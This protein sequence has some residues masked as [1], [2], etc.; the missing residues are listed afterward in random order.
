MKSLKSSSD[1]FYVPSK[2]FLWGEY[3]ALEGGS[4]G[5]VATE[6]CFAFSDA[7]ILLDQQEVSQDFTFHPESPAGKFIDHTRAKLN[8]PAEEVKALSSC[9]MFDPHHGAGG[10]GR[11]TAEFVYV[12]YK[13]KSRLDMDIQT[14]WE[15]YREIVPHAGT[16][17]LPPSGYDLV[18]QLKSNFNVIHVL[19]GQLRLMVKPWPFTRLS[20]LLF[21][22]KKKVFTHQHVSGLSSDVLKPLLSASE[23]VSFQYTQEDQE[24]FIQ[25]MTTFRGL[26]EESD[27]I[28]AE[29]LDIVKRL[30]DVPNISFAKGCGAL[31]ADVVA[32]FCKKQYKNQVLNEIGTLYAD[33]LR[34]VTDEDGVVFKN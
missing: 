28:C 32:V 2:T 19:S 9:Q 10:F 24:G 3:A 29:T 13:L 6:P 16:Q 1:I 7:K 20:F 23:K 12:A 22:T 18:T 27:L 25:A 30:Y 11:S 15:L 14:L 21:K 8:L 31:G 33:D 5:L 4:A 17:A 34:F 26:L